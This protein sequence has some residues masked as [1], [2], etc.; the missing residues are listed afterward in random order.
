MIINENANYSEK[1]VMPLVEECIAGGMDVR[2]RVSGIS[3]TP[4]LHNIKDS[5]VLSKADKVK[6]YDIVLYKRANGKYILHR[7]IGR[8]KGAFV[9]AGDFE[10]DKEYP[11]YENMIIAKVISFRRNGKDYTPEDFVIRLYSVL[12]V[13]VFPVRHWL[14]Y[15]LNCIRRI[16][17]GKR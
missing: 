17:H 16:F 12:W 9:M 8:K 3:M 14:L 4:I 6:K 13:L 7:I 2:M 10:T 1:D 11:V 15:T 5:V